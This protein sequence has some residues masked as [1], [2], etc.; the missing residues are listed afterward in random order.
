MRKLGPGAFP[1]EGSTLFGR[2]GDPVR[3]ARW[4]EELASIVDPETP[5]FFEIA[6]CYR[7]AAGELNLAHEYAG[8]ALAPREK[9]RSGRI[10]A[11]LY[12]M[13]GEFNASSQRLREGLDDEQVADLKV[14]PFPF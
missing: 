8:I 7:F 6:A 9:F 12:W 3:A 14:Q 13:H 10:E 1:Q 11:D 5:R 2:L 4:L